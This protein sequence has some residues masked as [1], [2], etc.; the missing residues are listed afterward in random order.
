[1]EKRTIRSKA[2]G[3]CSD[4][5]DSKDTMIPSYIVH[6]NDLINSTFEW[7]TKPY[8]HRVLYSLSFSILNLIIALLSYWPSEAF[9]GMIRIF[10]SKLALYTSI[11]SFLPLKGKVR[12]M[13][14]SRSKHK[15]QQ[16]VNHVHH[17]WDML[18][19]I[20]YRS[21][22]TFTLFSD[23]IYCIKIRLYICVY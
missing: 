21:C 19:V 3:W 22:L 7:S 15:T 9:V 17:S 14:S 2:L 11:I 5:I 20:I 16:F 12:W 8:S 6:S 1:M 4:Y 13:K 23:N 10:L 18:Y